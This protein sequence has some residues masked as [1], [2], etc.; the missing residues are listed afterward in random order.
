MRPDH[1]A[2]PTFIAASSRRAR[3]AI[4]VDV[5]VVA[6]THCNLEEEVTAGKFRE[7]LFYRLQVMP[8]TLPALRERR[9]DIP[10]LVAHYIEVYNRE[11]RKRVRGVMPEALALLEQYRWPGNVRELRNAIERAMLL[12][13]RDQLLPEDFATLSRSAVAARF[14][15]P[16]EGVS[17]DDVERQLVTQALERAR[18]NQ[19]QAGHLLGINR[20][21]VRYRIE[22][23]GLS[24]PER[25][26]VCDRNAGERALSDRFGRSGAMG[27]ALKEV[28]IDQDLWLRVCHEYTEMP[29][30]GLTVLQASR[31]WSTDLVSSQQV[32]DALVDAA[33]LDVRD[34]R[35]V[36]AETDHV[37]A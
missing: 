29:G 13:D 24:R 27:S 3:A 36:R 8:V 2:I 26:N 34:G 5:R 18:G 17:F 14:R 1:R 9:G 28:D 10:L 22:K 6:A 12:T 11:F 37:S 23:F 32:L 7:D 25:S 33:F 19:T 15:L 35:Y 4:P 31:L 20:D 30:L 21:Q 16:A